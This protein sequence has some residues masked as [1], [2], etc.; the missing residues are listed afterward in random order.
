M[1]LDEL[2]AAWDELSRRLDASEALA[3]ETRR[4]TKLAKARSQ[5]RPLAWGQGVQA[6]FWTVTIATVIAP[7]WVEHRAVTHLF[8]AGIVMHVYAVA[9][10]VLS[11][12]QLFQIVAV[13]YTKS[14]VDLQRHLAC[15]RRSRI[16]Q[17]LWLGLP[18]WVLWVVATMI[19]AQRLF[20]IDLYGNSP[21]WLNLSMGIGCIGIVVTLWLPR[22]IDSTPRGSRFV[23]RAL[24]DLAGRTLQRAS[25]QIDEVAQF[26]REV[27]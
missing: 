7:F 3:L 12:R 21:G 24:D 6:L 1:E 18:W 25:R 10:I 13:D 19:G 15:L 27:R 17:Q 26:A 4:E 16:R 22:V 11:V 5:L 8:V 9:A 20:G 14:V 2:K 23:Q